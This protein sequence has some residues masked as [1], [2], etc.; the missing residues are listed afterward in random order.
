MT[1]IGTRRQWDEDDFDC[2][3]RNS[4][5]QKGDMSTGSLNY[6]PL[7]HHVSFRVFTSKYEKRDYLKK[8][9]CTSYSYT[10]H[11]AYVYMHS[12]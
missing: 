8:V 4:A 3:E 1:S 6:F 9:P 7:S 5:Q 12:M 10:P 11:E 2:S